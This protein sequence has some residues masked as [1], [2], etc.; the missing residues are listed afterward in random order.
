MPRA[1]QSSGKL[2]EA[3]RPLPWSV[4]HQHLAFDSC[5]LELREDALLL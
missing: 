1:A 3:G 4:L 2:E 5:P